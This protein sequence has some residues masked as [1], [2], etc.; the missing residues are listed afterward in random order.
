MF[1]VK[2]PAEDKDL[3]ADHHYPEN[4]AEIIEHLDAKAKEL[5]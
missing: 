3:G 5:A 1:V 4:L 2:S